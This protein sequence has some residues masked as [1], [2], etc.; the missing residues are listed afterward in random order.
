MFSLLG[1]AGA[2]LLGQVTITPPPPAPLPPS[3]AA[4]NSLGEGQLSCRDW[5]SSTSNDRLSANLQ[6][7]SRGYV[8]GY[9][10]FRTDR[11]VPNMDMDMFAEALG[12]VTRFCQN[13][14]DRTIGL[15]AS[16]V[17]DPIVLRRRWQ[18][19]HPPQATGA[20]GG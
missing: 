6:A 13:S 19:Q 10:E 1:G 4:V 15:A 16:E 14:P 20:R 5:L 2:I 18:L 12:S 17:I 8:S 9:N 7:W 11:N 3:Q